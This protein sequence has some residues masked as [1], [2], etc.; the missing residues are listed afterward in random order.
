[1][2]GAGAA[3][4]STSAGS[5][6]G[7]N[8]KKWI[9]IGTAVLVVGVAVGLVAF[10]GGGGGGGRGRPEGNSPPTVAGIRFADGS[11]GNTFD[12]GRRFK[13]EVEASDADDDPLD[14]KW[15]FPSGI[16]AKSDTGERQV[17]FEIEDGLPGVEH[18][19]T[20]GVID[21]V[22]R[23]RGDP[24][25]VAQ[26]IVVGKC[27]EDLPLLGLNVSE[28]WT[29]NTESPIDWTPVSPPDGSESYVV[30]RHE[31]LRVTQTTDLRDERYWEW[32]GTLKSEELEV[33]DY[34]T[35]GLLFSFGDDGYAV[36]C[37]RFGDGSK[38]V[39]GILQRVRGTDELRFLPERP[40]V[41]FDEA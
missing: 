20:A 16:S 37:K 31:K 38:W 18:V 13:L 41:E 15:T 17:T 4:G 33:T 2:P 7:A 3:T 8:R 28:R 10:G 27:R 26:S 32:F 6:A 29:A 9:G 14:Y 24:V 5:G 23:W 21:M 19:I 12:L 34:A 40:V 30:G 25:T 22:G 1:L 36:Q 39:V 11:T 35:L